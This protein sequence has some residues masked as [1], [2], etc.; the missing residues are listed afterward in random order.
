MKFYKV[1]WEQYEKDCFVL[2]RKIKHIKFDKIVAISRG[3]L[4]AARIFSDLLDLS[5][6]SKPPTKK[7]RHHHRGSLNSFQQ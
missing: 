7:I 4:V 2:S 3:G 6:L 1:S 5:I